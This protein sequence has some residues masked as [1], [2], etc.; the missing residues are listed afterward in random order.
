[1]Y[2]YD[3]IPYARQYTRK[4][5]W[6]FAHFPNAGYLEHGTGALDYLI[7]S[8]WKPTRGFGFAF[9]FREKLDEL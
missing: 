6:A 2:L 4:Q 1:M 8:S 7:A 3:H 9:S 5:S